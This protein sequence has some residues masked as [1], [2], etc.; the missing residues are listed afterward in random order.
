MALGFERNHLISATIDFSKLLA[1][2]AEV[3]PITTP[4]HTT[5]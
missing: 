2:W 4:H 3:M 5:L 1:A